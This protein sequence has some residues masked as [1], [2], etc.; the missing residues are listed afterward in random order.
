MPST[1]PPWR[2]PRPGLT[3]TCP[4]AS[5]PRSVA[6]RVHRH[7]GRPA[8]RRRPAATAGPAGARAGPVRRGGAPDGGRRGPADRGRARATCCPPWPPD[9]AP[10]VP[11]IA[12]ETDSES[13]AGL[14]SRGGRGLRPRRRGAARRR[15]SPTGSPGRSRWTR[16][17]GS[18]PARAS[19]R[20][21]GRRQRAGIV[22]GLPR[23]TAS[24]NRLGYPRKVGAE[25]RISRQEH[26]GNPAPARR[27]AGRATA[28][29]G[30]AGQPSPGRAAPVLD[31]RRPDR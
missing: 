19:P 9:I 23:P 11:V 20:P 1:R 21:R 18:S 8:G 7:R 4:A 30:A 10:D 24:R 13:L 6:R 3:A 28:G 27:R 17:S 12:L 14:L 26:P 16:N 5:S 25:R 15:S 31:N 29:G 2:R 22:P